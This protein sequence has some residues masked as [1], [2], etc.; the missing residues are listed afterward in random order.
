[1]SRQIRRVL[2]FNWK[3]PDTLTVELLTGQE[4]DDED[5]EEIEDEA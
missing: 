4:W 2:F 3:L 5:E 1:L